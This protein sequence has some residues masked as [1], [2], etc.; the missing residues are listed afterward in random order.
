MASTGT[1]SAFVSLLGD[2]ID[3][4]IHA[5]HQHER[6]IWNIDFGLH[7][8]GGFI[9]LVRKSGD[10]AGKS[11]MQSGHSHVYGFAPV[12][13][14]TADSGTGK[15]QP[16]QAVFGEPDH[17]HSL[18]LRSGACLNQ[19]TGVGV[20]LRHDARERRRDDGVLIQRFE[21]RLVGLRNANAL[22]A[23]RDVRFRPGN[24]R[25]GH[26]IAR[27]RFVDFLLGNQ[28]GLLFG[29]IQDPRIGQWAMS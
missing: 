28:S 7:G 21:P 3:F 17:G 23:C 27:V 18:S 1:V 25:L 5:R 6:R 8:S 9:D 10:T 11:P 2:Q 24:L 15:R 29:D 26:Q 12:N 16:Q 20:S 22:L 14:G 19:G 13:S 4:R